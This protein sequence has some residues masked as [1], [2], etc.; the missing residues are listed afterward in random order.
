MMIKKPI[1]S[2]IATA[3]T[4]AANPGVSS[5]DRAT[6]SEQPERMAR[7]HARAEAAQWAPIAGAGVL[8]VSV[9]VYWLADVDFLALA[10]GVF[11]AL[12]TGAVVLAVRVSWV[13]SR[14]LRTLTRATERATWARE[15]ATGE[16]LTGD[17]YIG[18][19]F[20]RVEVKRE[21]ETVAEVIVP[22]PSNSAK[23]EKKME[24]WGVSASDLVAFVFE[25]E[26]GR[27]LNERAWVGE[28]IQRFHLPSGAVVT[29]PLFRQVLAALAEH[30]LDGRPMA[31]KEAQRWILKARAEAIARKMKP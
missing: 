21:G 30:E 15:E 12:L 27:G 11:A 22:R 1:A 23:H 9:V 13:Y 5:T 17:G 18:D 14:E 4:I 7:N 16:D 25:A 31:V 20:N 8:V 26:A 29:Q 28:G 3:P 2:P 24:G 10:L 19:P 6:W